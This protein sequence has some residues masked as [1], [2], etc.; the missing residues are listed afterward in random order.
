MNDIAHKLEF[1]RYISI[2]NTLDNIK[3]LIAAHKDDDYLSTFD[4][5]SLKQLHDYVRSLPYVDDPVKVPINNGDD[6][7][8]LKSPY[9]VIYTGGDC[10][11]KFILMGAIL[12]RLKISYRAAVVCTVDHYQKEHSNDLH[13]IYPE[14]F[15]YNMW[16][17]FDATYNWNEPFLEMPFIRK[18]IYDWNCGPTLIFE[19]DRNTPA[20]HGDGMLYSNYLQTLKADPS[21]K[22]IQTL[23][24]PGLSGN[25]AQ[26]AILQGLNGCNGCMPLDQ[27]LIGMLN[28][29]SPGT[30][31]VL[32]VAAIIT[33]AAGAFQLFSG[34][35]GHT[36]Y[37]D[38]YHAWEQSN[39]ALVN[40]ANAWEASQHT[41]MNALAQ[42]SMDRAVIAVLSRDYMNPPMGADFCTSSNKCGNRAE[43]DPI[44]NDVQQKAAALSPFFAWFVAVH[45]E[46]AGD[47][48]LEG[49]VTK[50]DD[51]KNNGPLRQLYNS[52]VAANPS[53]NVLG[54][55]NVL[56]SG[57]NLGS[58]PLLIIG[59][60][61]VVIYFLS[62]KKSTHK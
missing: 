47:L 56:P 18:K 40:A 25:N 27:E 8:L 43:W 10:D 42:L 14:I 30:L 32:P 4:S 13:H 11:D 28:E 36:P 46:Q 33:L 6:I 2:D 3:R 1:K 24:G 26:L 57:L 9:F 21:V 49:L 20:T 45:G 51:F 54:P 52:F 7:E 22:N 31:G 37:I 15:I 55:Q 34:M 35:F 53:Q 12:E 44:K 41:D 60:A 5:W 17:P 29:I 58:N 16:L 61:G 39:N 48:S 19:T 59:I 50:Y 62:Q 23:S 38:A